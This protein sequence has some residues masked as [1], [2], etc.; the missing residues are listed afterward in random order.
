MSFWRNYYHIVWTTKNRE[1][2]LQPELERAIFGYI[3]NK[4]AEMD[5]FIYAIGGCTDHI[6][7]VV[8]IPPK[9]SVSSVVKV[10]KGSSSH[11]INHVI[12]PVYGQFTWQHGYG[13]MTMGESQLPAAKSYV[14][15]QNQHHEN[16][17]TNSWLE[18]CEELDEG[19]IFYDRYESSM[20]LIQE[21]NTIYEVK[22]GKFPF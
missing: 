5:S 9:H 13:C 12:R 6:H 3:V 16:Q 15:N 1:P 18:R 14:L 22:M 7:I 21:E 4:G 11:N 17:T 19:P 20:H 2:L 8:A 10:L